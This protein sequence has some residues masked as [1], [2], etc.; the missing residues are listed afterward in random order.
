MGPGIQLL[1]ILAASHLAAGED[2]ARARPS[3]A[4]G[5]GV[6]LSIVVTPRT[7]HGGAEVELEAR[8]QPRRKATFLWRVAEGTLHADDRRRVTWRT[9]D[10]VGDVEVRLE[11]RIVGRPPTDPPLA[12][13]R[14][15]R[16]RRTR[17]T[18]MVRIPG[19]VYTIGDTWTDVDR[20]D[21]ILTGQNQADKPPHR[22]T[23]RPY[24][25]DRDR[26]TNAQYARFLEMAV[27]QDLAEVTPVAVMG[28]HRGAL[29]PY[30]RFSFD[31]MK[32]LEGLPKL[33]GVIRWDGSRLRVKKGHERHP[34]VD[35]T[36]P[37]ADAY[38]RFHGKRLPTSAEWEISGRGSDGRRFPWGDELPSPLH[39]NVNH[40]YGDRLFPVG[41]FSPLGDSPFGVRDLVGGVFE[42][43]A[44]WYNEKYYADIAASQPVREPRGPHWGRDHVIRGV[45][46]TQGVVGEH[47]EQPPL[48]FRYS[49]FFEV[50]IGD[51]VATT[52]TGFRT[53]ADD[54]ATRA[55]TTPAASSGDGAP[56]SASVPEAAAGS[57]SRPPA[58]AGEIAPP[59]GR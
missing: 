5:D 49:W 29:V 21:F 2:A 19:G 11:A 6:R 45:P 23:V 25:I 30:Y 8:L 12:T 57:P 40:V 32:H 31:D 43:V 56:R 55:A 59:P 48:S 44:D 37:G 7:A 15:G 33:R 52:D 36:W 39:A 27:R 47:S 9:P 18:G 17:R 14:R 34:V 46:A 54:P 24:Y 50:P 41:S 16:L 51:G 3:P 42:W 28:R 13:R 10:R 1:T 53:A 4:A 35:V 26:V 20:P 38:A 22:V 58:G